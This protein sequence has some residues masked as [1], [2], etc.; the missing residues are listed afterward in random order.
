MRAPAH[1]ENMTSEKSKTDIDFDDRFCKGCA[2]CIHY[3]TQK[4]LEMSSE[5]NTKGYRIP[6]VSDS[7]KCTRCRICEQICPEFAITVK[8]AQE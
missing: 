1:E 3:C 8:E 2:L 5:T 4:I 6:C 7:E